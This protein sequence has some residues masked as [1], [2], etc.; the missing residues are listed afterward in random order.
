MDLAL[1][2]GVVVVVL[3]GAVVYS[4]MSALITADRKRGRLDALDRTPPDYKRLPDRP[5]DRKMGA[6]PENPFPERIAETKAKA[7]MGRYAIQKIVD[8]D[9]KGA[10]KVVSR[11]NEQGKA[12]RE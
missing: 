4:V 12:E 9:P 7:M 1:M 2:I 6:L 11:W 5:V 10:A 8:M 3:V